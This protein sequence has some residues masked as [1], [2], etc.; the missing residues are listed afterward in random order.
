MSTKIKGYALGAIAAATY[1]LNPL[2][3]LPLYA[4]GMD[5][6]SV[7]FLRYVL[8][9]PMMGI[10]ILSRRRNFKVSR[11]YLPALLFVSLMMAASSLALFKSYSFMDAGIASTLL[12]VYPL[13]VAGIMAA[14]FNERLSFFTMA[15]IL[16]ALTG[17][18][19]LFKASDGSTLSLPGTILVML[20]SLSYAIYIVGVNRPGLRQVPTVKMIFYVLLCGAMLFGLKIALTPDATLLLPQHWY[21]WGN[22]AALALLPTVISFICTTS[23]I[24]YIGP[25]PTAILGAL[26]PATAV[27]I[28]VT[29]FG[30]TLTARDWVGLLLIVG[31]VSLVVG[32]GRITSYLVRFRRLFPK[33]KR[34]REDKITH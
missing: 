32:G 25:T 23:A 16:V 1:G 5:A 17:I 6:D 4:D 3:A 13:M 9:V 2:F 31:A 26:E 22:I 15:C 11:S 19:L 21:M 14:F 29:V 33:G 10:M 18:G 28:G 8:A 34:K 12:F 27:I 20:S 30:E 7:L 24:Q